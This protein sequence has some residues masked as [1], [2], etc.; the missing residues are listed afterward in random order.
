MISNSHVQG[1]IKQLF[2]SDNKSIQPNDILN[3]Y[4]KQGKITNPSEL[5]LNH[6]ILPYFQE[7]DKSI[8]K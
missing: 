7:K 4:V 6:E 3:L 5:S 8:S 2:P 1:L